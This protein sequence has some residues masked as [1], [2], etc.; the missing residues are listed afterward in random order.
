MPRYHVVARDPNSWSPVDGLCSLIRTCGHK[1]RS[2]EAA[3]RCRTTLLD[4]NTRTNPAGSWCASWH[5]AVV[6]EVRADGR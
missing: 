1:H 5:N 2:E 6:E 3:D 4:Y